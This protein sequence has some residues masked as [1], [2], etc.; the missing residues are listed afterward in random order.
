[1]FDS[2]QIWGAET[3]PE[4]P[5][6]NITIA[7]GE[8]SCLLGIQ[9]GVAEIEL[10]T[11]RMLRTMPTPA[12][13]RPPLFAVSADG[14]T[15]VVRVADGIEVRRAGEEPPLVLPLGSTVWPNPDGSLLLVRAPWDE[16][17]NRDGAATLLRWRDRASLRSSD[18]GGGVSVV[19]WL[20]D[21]VA[22][23]DRHDT[24]HLWGADGHAAR[25]SIP[26][27]VTG[28]VPL[29]FEGESFLLTAMARGRGGRTELRSQT[30]GSVLRVLSET[31]SI[32]GA[33]S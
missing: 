33:G 11:G 10:A 23:A 5:W 12:S 27:R 15:T 8:Q 32:T 22:F 24:L 21:R 6:G 9:G 29:V 13:S 25:V 20:G 16:V 17:R 19:A 30:D 2:Q 18:A 4:G 31:R 28:L 14:E 7:P 26:G 3:W 1:M